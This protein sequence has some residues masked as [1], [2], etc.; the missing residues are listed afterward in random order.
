MRVKLT[1]CVYD[2]VRVPTHTMRLEVSNW[3]KVG[4]EDRSDVYSSSGRGVGVCFCRCV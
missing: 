1:W 2:C 4:H 3:E